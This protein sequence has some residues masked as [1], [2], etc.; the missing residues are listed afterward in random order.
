LIVLAVHGLIRA[1]DRATV[2]DVAPEPVRARAVTRGDL[3]AVVSAVPDEGPAAEDAVPHLDLLV[4]LVARVPVL[5]LAL[6]TIARDDDAVRDEILA[7][8][9]ERFARQ[10][11]ALQDLVELRLELGFDPDVAAA[12]VAQDAE[13]RALA[14]A[15][16][17]PRAGMAEQMA[18]GEAVAQRVADRVD[19]LTGAWT[20]EL[21]SIA[22]RSV[23]LSATEQ[24]VRIAL[25]V[26]RDRVPDA[27]DAVSR[28]REAADGQASVEYVG[29]LPAY[30]FLD[31]VA[32]PAS[33]ADT[34]R[35]GW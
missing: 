13:V 12:A 4:A 17:A 15:A 27:D 5:P 16:R 14:R 35:W 28:L 11:D 1:A 2:A 34:S 25:L 20:Q 10:L 32:E 3:A 29:P 9:A 21:A 22:E 19:A 6:G 31:E 18:L 26:R 7:P 24:D 30:S 23:V 8:E 33:P